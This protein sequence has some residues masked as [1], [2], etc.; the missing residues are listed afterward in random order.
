MAKQVKTRKRKKVG[1]QEKS[2]CWQIVIVQ[3]VK[4]F[5]YN[6]LKYYKKKTIEKKKINKKLL[7]QM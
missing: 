3:T 1:K 6:I 7:I 2:L 4:N 5:F